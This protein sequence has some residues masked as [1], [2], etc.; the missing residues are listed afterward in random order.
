MVSS[1][2]PEYSQEARAA[3]LQGTVSLYLNVGKDGA[4]T[5]V[6]VLHGLG[7]GLDENAVRAVSQWRFQPAKLNGRVIEIGMSVDAS[8]GFDT[9]P[10]WYVRLADYVVERGKQ[11]ESEKPVLLNYAAPDGTCGTPGTTSILKFKVSASGIPEAVQP[12]EPRDPLAKV[13]AEAVLAWRYRPAKVNGEPKEV[14]ASVEFECGPPA[15]VKIEPG[16]LD[17][18]PQQIFKREP[19]YTTA[20]QQAKRKGTVRIALMVDQSGH[21]SNAFVI[22]SLGIGLDE[23]AVE[24]VKTWRFRPATRGGV[25]VSTNAT[26]VVDF[27]IK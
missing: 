24:A 4:P 27:R 13:A 25:P 21:T 22:E 11:T 16:K 1:V 8:F 2:A 18:V 23:K 17:T 12:L 20:A 10:S 19:I 5:S 14:D 26:V 3:R 7:L 15:P 6:Q 9:G